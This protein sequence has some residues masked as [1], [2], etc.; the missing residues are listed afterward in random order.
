M[1]KQTQQLYLT[2]KVSFQ[3]VG[4]S[5][6]NFPPSKLWMDVLV[7]LKGIFHISIE[8]AG[9]WQD[10]VKII[11]EALSSAGN[12]KQDDVVILEVKASEVNQVTL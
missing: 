1:Q 8:S 11:N 10:S 2:V 12:V 5:I 4:K 9:K 6:W 7:R 3:K